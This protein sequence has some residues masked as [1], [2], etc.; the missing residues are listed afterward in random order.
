MATPPDGA[1]TGGGHGGESA[2][3]DTAPPHLIGFTWADLEAWTRLGLIRPD[4]LAAI[5]ASV[6]GREASATPGAARRE[7][8]GGFDLVS[9]AYYFGGFMILLAYTIFVGLRWEDLG[10]GGQLAI[11]LTSVGGLWA[12]GGWLR[13][14]GHPLGGNLLIF[15]GTGIVPLAVSSALGAGGLWPDDAEAGA[16]R[17]FYRTITGTWLLL[18]GVSIAVTLAVLRLVRFP[19]LTLLLAFWT[20]YI[21]MDLAEFVGGEERWSW[22]TTE[23][24][25]GGGVGLALLA[26][27]VVLQLRR[28][29]QDYSRWFYLFG[30][31]AV[32]G[33]VSALALD[34]GVALGLLFLLLYLGFVVA[35]VWLQV[36]VFLVFGALGCYAYASYLAFDVFAGALGFVF[37]LA[38]VGLVV[39]LSTVAYQ[40]WGR[41]WLVARLRPRPPGAA[42][43]A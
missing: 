25:V 11:A 4:Q 34:D 14:L 9:I 18:E 39:V 27:G 2:P 19:L 16:Y 26:L 15:A 40:R 22:G 7:E 8:R 36:H 3:S 43:P 10:R 20:W 42:A 30:H 23:W 21:S 1:G 41:D 33:T 29:D 17:E 24:L 12:C 37:A 31:L 38:A 5:R 35:S 32:F 6:A 28:G 13:R